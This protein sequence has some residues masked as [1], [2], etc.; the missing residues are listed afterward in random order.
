MFAAA[1]EQR[2]TAKAAEQSGYFR[3]W[4]LEPVLTGAGGGLAGRRGP[5][6]LLAGEL[7]PE[8][9]AQFQ[10]EATAGAD[11]SLF[12]ADW[13]AGGQLPPRVS[14][15]DIEDGIAAQLVV[16]G[17]GA[18]ASGASG[19][20]CGKPPAT[21]SAI[22]S[23]DD[24][25]AAFREKNNEVIADMRVRIVRRLEALGAEIRGDN[26]GH[27]TEHTHTGD[28]LCT[29]TQTQANLVGEG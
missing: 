9:L 8:I 26:G 10:R 7:A 2:L 19:S 21:E 16:T 6:R 4:A 12:I 27:A 11:T 20:M 14:L 25:A 3:P 5:F 15:E 18:D 29:T 24:F 13:R 1:P 17:R 28:W 23:Q 22:R